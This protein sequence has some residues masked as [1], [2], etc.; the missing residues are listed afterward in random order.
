M[1]QRFSLVVFDIGGVLVQ[2]GRTWVE[3]AERAGFTFTP[4]WLEQFQARARAL[5]NRNVGAIDS[6]RYFVLLAE[7]SEGVLT[8]DDARRISDASLVAEYPGIGR[9]FDALDAAAIKTAVLSNVNDAEWGRLFPEHGARAEFPTLLRARYRFASHI[10]G[11]RKPEAQAFDEVER[12]TG[13]PGREILFLDDRTENVDAARL[14][15]W[16]AE[17][18]D[19]T[20]DTAPQILTVLREHGAID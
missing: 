12:A 4:S 9:V 6:D 1:K 15:G 13:H 20:G 11:V 8:A 2:A 3:D 19:H 10:M 17:L 18:I 14:F 5:P 7:E 16:T